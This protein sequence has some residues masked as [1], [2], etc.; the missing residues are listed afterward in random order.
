MTYYT[1]YLKYKNKYLDLKY[2]SGNMVGG[3][4]DVEYIIQNKN[5]YASVLRVTNDIKKIITEIFS[6]TVKPTI[7][8]IKNS[9]IIEVYIENLIKAMLDAQVV[10]NKIYLD[11]FYSFGM[12]SMN[13][14]SGYLAMTTLYKIITYPN[15][16]SIELSNIKFDPGDNLNLNQFTEKSNITEL[17]IKMTTI[18]DQQILQLIEMCPNLVSIT[19]PQDIY[20]I[21]SA[22]STPISEQL[23]QIIPNVKLTINESK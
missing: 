15:L 2:Y 9:Y 23:K 4:T 13:I 17:I 16:K 3:T 7:L 10:L 20:L 5:Y 19:I 11:T 21:P 14:T 22:G 18:T 8:K 6:F 1:K 12:H